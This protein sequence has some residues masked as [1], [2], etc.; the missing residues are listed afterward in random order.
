MVPEHSSSKNKKAV[1][2]LEDG[3][4]FF[5]RNSGKTQ[6][7]SGK[8]VF[9]T[10][11]AGHLEAFSHQLYKGQNPTSTYPLAG[12]C[13][14]L[15]SDLNLASKILSASESNHIQITSLAMNSVC[16]EPCCW[17]P[18]KTFGQCPAK[19]VTKTM[20]DEIKNAKNRVY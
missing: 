10:S 19:G 20:G 13:S 4:F 17:V 8:S 18:V 5:G 14:V 16:K 7:I 11:M 1:L 15:R 3:T 2:L 6:R 9:L 12:A